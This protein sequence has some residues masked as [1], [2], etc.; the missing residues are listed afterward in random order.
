MYT[1]SLKYHGYIANY[2]IKH[3]YIVPVGYHELGH[4][5][6]AAMATLLC[7]YLTR[8]AGYSLHSKTGTLLQETYTPKESIY[9]LESGIPVVKNFWRQHNL[10]SLKT[11]PT[12]SVLRVYSLHKRPMDRSDAE[13]TYNSLRGITL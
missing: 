10:R 5:C 6:L 4:N 12:V 11:C 13:A 1:S 3:G 7:S 8:P 9:Y 2:S